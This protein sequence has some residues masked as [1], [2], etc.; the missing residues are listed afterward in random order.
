VVILVTNLAFF[1]YRQFIAGALGVTLPALPG[2]V[3]AV[4]LGISFYTFQ[5]IASL[6]DASDIE[7]GDQ[8]TPIKPQRFALFVLFFPHLIAGPICRV[9][10]LYPQFNYAKRFRA[11]FLA[12]G[13]QL[14][15]IGYCKKVLIADPIA[16]AIDPLWHTAN[17]A[18]MPAATAW[19]MVIGFYIQVYAD[20]SGYTDMGRGVA[21][22]MGFR[23]PINFR[24]P[25]LAQTPVDFWSRWHI[26]LSKFA[27]AYIYNPLA[28]ATARRFRSA[29]QA[30]MLFSLIA[31]MVLLG[32]WH[33]AAWRFV[34]FGLVQ[35]IL[36]AVWYGATRSRDLS[37]VPGWIL[38]QGL[39]VLS[40]VVFRAETMQATRGLLASMFGGGPPTTAATPAGLGW[41][42]LLTAAAVFTIQ[43]VDYRATTRPFAAWLLLPRRM[44]WVGFVFLAVF[45]AAFAAKRQM[46]GVGG[47][48]FE[49]FIYFDF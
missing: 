43:S 14:F 33:G 40:F 5:I 2:L 49:R 10:Q 4:P 7:G 11:G 12:A 18:S 36:L 30:G 9:R 24:A 17:G 25:Y 39:L 42:V 37:G 27:K 1:K 8:H 29:R 38:T 41:L 44:P 26:T 22:A 19:L 35:G 31:T 6:S 46:V 32:L 21:R 13:A 16:R 15:A 20:F 47:A 48:A 23:L 3:W 34:L 28:V 45:I